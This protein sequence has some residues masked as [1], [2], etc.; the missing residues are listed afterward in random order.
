MTTNPRVH[1]WIS[2]ALLSL[3]GLMAMVFWGPRQS[4]PVT[5]RPPEDAN[6]LRVAYTQ[7]LLPDPHRR[8][9]P[10]TEHNNFILSLWEPLV[11]CDPATGE[12]QPAA[13]FRT[14]DPGYFKA[15]GISIVKARLS[16]VSVQALYRPSAS[17]KCTLKR[18]R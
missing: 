10:I 16:V 2:L 14:A 11:E 6:I 8:T 12:P 7:Y 13:E 4:L 17:G 9:F 18:T 5:P 15:S 3:G 1:W